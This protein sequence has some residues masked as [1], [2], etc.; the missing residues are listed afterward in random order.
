MRISDWSSDV[1][2]SDLT[3]R[4]SPQRLSHQR[5]WRIHPMSAGWPASG[6]LGVRIADDVRVL[7]GGRLLVGG[8]PLTVLRLSPVA[9][10]LLHQGQ[11]TV[12]S[13]TGAVL[14]ERLLATNIA[15][16]LLDDHPMP[17]PRD[18]TVVIPVRDRAAQLDRALAA[19][20]HLS[21]L[22]VDDGSADPSALAAVAT[23]RGADRSDEHT[24]E[25]KYLHRT[26]NPDFSLKNKTYN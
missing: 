16:P 13:P 4:R 8:S 22:V 1:C 20:D 12:S 5:R 9:A 25:L 24:Y 17:D 2:S 19:L 14:T 21:C 11:M 6:H 15:V 10:D 18:I 23:A 7:D 26:T 3:R